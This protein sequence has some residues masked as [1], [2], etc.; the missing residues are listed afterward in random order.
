MDIVCQIAGST[1]RTIF[2]AVLTNGTQAVIA[3]SGALA[4]LSSGSW[5]TFGVA[6]TDPDSVAIYSTNVPANTP[7]G[8]YTIL[9]YQKLGGSY[10]LSDT[11]IASQTL[12]W[13]GTKVLNLLTSMGI[14]DTA[15]DHNTGGANNLAYQISGVGIIGAV[16]RA[17]LKTEFDAGN[18]TVRGATK[19]VGPDGTWE[20]PLWL[21]AGHD[22]VITFSMPS[23][24]ME[25]SQEITI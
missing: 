6:L 4:T 24:Y 17:Y 19:T 3:S 10:A 13:D 14:G 25:S 7:R 16:V 18:Y 23:L 22:Y 2:Y 9:I 12:L 5:T 20:N 11:L 8:T 1:G 15:V 21:A